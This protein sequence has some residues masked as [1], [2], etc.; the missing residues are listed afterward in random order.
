MAEQKRAALTP[1]QRKRLLHMGPTVPVEID[2]AGAF[3]GEMPTSPAAPPGEGPANL[4]AAQALEESE[5]PAFVPLDARPVLAVAEGVVPWSDL[6]SL[7]TEILRR[8]DGA[9]SAMS[10]VTGL[11]AAPSDGIRVLASLVRRGLVRLVPPIAGE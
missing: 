1:Q 5:V 9:K 2:V 7:A 3:D 10:I 6:G 4:V 11:G 8:V